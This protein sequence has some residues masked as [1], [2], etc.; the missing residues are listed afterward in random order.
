M[1]FTEIYRLHGLEVQVKSTP[2]LPV[3]DVVNER[4]IYVDIESDIRTPA[5]VILT[6]N[7]FNTLVLMCSLC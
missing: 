4:N 5:N 7:T 6:D 3:V 2:D 1:V